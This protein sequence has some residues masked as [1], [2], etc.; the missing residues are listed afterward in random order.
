MEEK[1]LQQLLKGIRGDPKVQKA[2][3]RLDAGVGTYKE[4]NTIALQVGERIADEMAITFDSEALRRYLV[5]GHGIIN[6]TAELAQ[7]NLNNAAGIGIAPK[8]TKVPSYKIDTAIASITAVEEDNVASMCMNVVPSL[9]LEMV[10]DIERYNGDFQKDAGLKPVIK[11]IWSGSYPSHDTRHTDNC[12]Q[13][14]GEWD[15]GSEP[16]ETYWRHE[17]CRCT[18]EIFPNEQTARE[19]IEGTT[20]ALAKYEVDREGVLYSTKEETLEKRLKDAEE[21][22]RLD[23]KYRTYSKR[24]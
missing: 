5:A 21:R 13:F 23:K 8:L 4:V 16:S 2:I 14:A 9:M 6:M 18:V 15:L 17:G 24:K 10:D 19:G 22:R 7:T 1:E 11:R 12:E 20:A 3:E